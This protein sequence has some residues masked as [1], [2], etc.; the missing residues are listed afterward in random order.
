MA[1][2]EDLRKNAEIGVEII[3]EYL[4][5]VRRGLPTKEE[6]KKLEDASAAV[7]RYERYLATPEGMEEET[8]AFIKK[9]AQTMPDRRERLKAIDV[10]AVVKKTRAEAAEMRKALRR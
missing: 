3:S 6:M 9:V 8:K 5:A 2:K 7:M 4:K 1:H 10:K